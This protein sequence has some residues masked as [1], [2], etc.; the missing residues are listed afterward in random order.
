MTFKPFHFFAVVLAGW[1]NREQQDVI[2]YLREENRV[3][4]E[5]FGNKRIR[6]NDNQ[7]CRL[8]AA[9][10]RMGKDVLRGVTDLFSPETLLRWQRWFVAR[11]YDGSGKRGPATA[12]IPLSMTVSA[13]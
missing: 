11:K 6:L 5:K 7:R 13:R 3:L 12:P 8:A 1:L 9:A 4:R 2:A 10:A